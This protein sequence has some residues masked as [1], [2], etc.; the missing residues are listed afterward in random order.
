MKSSFMISF[1]RRFYTRF[2]EYFVVFQARVTINAHVRMV[3]VVYNELAQ[4]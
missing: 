1:A 4:L 3:K 2:A